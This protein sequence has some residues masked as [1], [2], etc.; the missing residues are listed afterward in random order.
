MSCCEFRSSRACVRVVTR[1][2]ARV[3]LL[4]A[5]ELVLREHIR[6][7]RISRAHASTISFRLRD[8]VARAVV[9]LSNALLAQFDQLARLNGRR[10]EMRSDPI[11]AVNPGLRA[12]RSL[13]VLVR[14][15]RGE[16]AIPV[17]SPDPI[18]HFLHQSAFA[19]SR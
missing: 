16:S 4:D 11:R 18:H 8:S 7:S 13:I 2:T 10:D 1:L 3:A 19:E 5:S 9:A 12:D 6:H 15:A 14:V 17:A